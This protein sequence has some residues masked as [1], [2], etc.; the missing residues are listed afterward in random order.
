MPDLS[1]LIAPVGGFLAGIAVVLAFLAARYRLRAKRLSIPF[2]EFEVSRFDQLSPVQLFSAVSVVA[3]RADV[4][5]PGGSS[6]A[7]LLAGDGKPTPIIMIHAGWTMVC[8]TYVRRFKH[9]PDQ[10]SVLKV[11]AEIGVQNAEFVNVYRRV[12]EN[13]IRHPKQITA[14]FAKD[15]LDRAPALSQRIDADLDPPRRGLVYDLLT[16]G[17]IR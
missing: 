17:V 6:E 10:E 8:E 11:V 14:A 1:D 7:Q 9:Y 3:L 5:L 2:V 13:A 4:P 15:Y 12:Y 16:V